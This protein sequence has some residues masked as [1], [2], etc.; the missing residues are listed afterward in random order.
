MRS[1]LYLW[2]P[3]KQGYID[4]LTFIK[5]M[6]FERIQPIFANAEAEAKEYGKQLWNEIMSRPCTE[7][8]YVDPGD[9]V[10]A[11]QEKEIERYS[12]LELMHYRNLVSWISNMCQV[13]EQQLLSFVLNEAE[14]EG[15][16]YDPAEVKR[17][18]GFAKDV[19]ELHQQPFEKLA[20]WE[21]IRELR[22]LVNT[23][24]H[25]EGDSEQKLRKI[26][27]DFFVQNF[28]GTDYDMTSLYHTTLLETT[29][30][31]TEADFIAYYDAL[32]QFWNELPER[33]YTAEEI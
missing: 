6:F 3:L 33:M 23:I 27:P 12:M 14:T 11:V 26:R 21:K 16:R 8:T 30:A 22:L 31:V 13:W 29:L 17:G 28:F 25:A 5:G 24:K 32:V 4:D 18:F 20:S 1:Q 10:D 19:F 9:Y 7:D 15:I 2:G